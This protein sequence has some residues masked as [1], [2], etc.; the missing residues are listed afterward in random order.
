MSWTD[1]VKKLLS[2][3]PHI[4][5]QADDTLDVFGLSIQ[6]SP[7][8]HVSRDQWLPSSEPCQK[9][10]IDLGSTED[11][12]RGI[13]AGIEYKPNGGNT[14][15]VVKS[16]M[17]FD[18]DMVALGL[19]TYYAAL[20]D[21]D[22]EGNFQSYSLHYLAMT[23]GDW[24]N[25]AFFD[26][27]FRSFQNN[28]EKDV[29]KDPNIY[30][31]YQSR[32]GVV[33]YLLAAANIDKEHANIFCNEAAELGYELV[34]Q[35]PDSKKVTQEDLGKVNYKTLFASD[36]SMVTTV[37]DVTPNLLSSLEV[38]LRIPAN[39]YKP[40][41]TLLYKNPDFF[42]NKIFT[43][44]CISEDL[45]NDF[46]NQSC[47]GRRIVL[48]LPKS[49]NSRVLLD[50]SG[51]IDISPLLRVMLDWQEGPAFVSPYI[52][53]TVIHEFIQWRNYY[54][55]QIEHVSAFGEQVR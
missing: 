6:D 18:K 24:S 10:Q 52:A 2:P 31:F 41:N 47:V 29:L 8:Q 44:P 20:P 54:A 5:I 43:I 34:I 13:L 19:M 15:E 14:S 51:H 30:K 35:L 21:W 45:S 23:E 53:V 36:A 50:H 3:N 22:G 42:E 1:Q 32:G 39:P 17:K 25:F 4:S 9:I 7:R 33:P 49:E 11:Q 38:S 28:Y 40:F 27:A 55:Y 16:K 26:S 37:N 46:G 48:T 12:I